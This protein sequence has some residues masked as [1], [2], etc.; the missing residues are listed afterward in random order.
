MVYPKLKEIKKNYFGYREVAK[1]LGITLPSAK[2]ACAR[3]T[4]SGILLRI[5]RNIYLFK[6][7]WDILDIEEKF[8]LANL[9]Q[10]PSYISLMTAMSYFE[11]TT[12]VQR[13]F[14]ESIAIYRTKEI[15]IAETV[16]R[17]SKIDKKLYSGFMKNKGF[18]IAAPEKA[19][20]DAFYL[21][22][23]KRYGFDLTSIDFKK[24][25]AAKIKRI[26]KQYP[27]KTQ[28]LL[29]NYGYFKKA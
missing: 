21:M 2:V 25:N 7:K 29:E 15:K 26:I 1:V 19:F 11:I 10:A 17:Y 13:D 22:S 20:L 18:F 28:K 27:Q 4:K 12:Q 23:L 3:Y 16:L 8:A 9:I 5:K 14:I 24:L 6:D